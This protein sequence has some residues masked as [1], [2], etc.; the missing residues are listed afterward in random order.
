M[1][2]NQYYF[3]HYYEAFNLKLRQNWRVFS[4]TDQSCPLT[5]NTK[6]GVKKILVTYAK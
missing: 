4:C 2:I 3:M 6:E 5:H 1:E